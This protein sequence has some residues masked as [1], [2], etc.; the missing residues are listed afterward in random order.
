MIH[1]PG[2]KPPG[3]IHQPAL[4]TLLTRAQQDRHRLN[5]GRGQHD[6]IPRDETAIAIGL[7]NGD[8]SGDF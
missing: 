6:Q 7:I 5:G 2:P 1:Q 8:N 4:L 3:R